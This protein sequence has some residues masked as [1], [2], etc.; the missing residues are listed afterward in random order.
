MFC[1]KIFKQNPVTA[2]TCL[3]VTKFSNKKKI[4][5]TFKIEKI[6]KKKKKNYSIFFLIL[7]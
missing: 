2:N 5:D 6:I 1:L 4:L 7:L 3:V